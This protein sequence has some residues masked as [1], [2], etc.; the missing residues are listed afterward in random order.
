MSRQK[1]FAAGVV[2]VYEERIRRLRN[3]LKN[4][5]NFIVKSGGKSLFF[6][7]HSGLEA[8]E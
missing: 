6:L 7:R 1:R 2:C 8:S 3:H 5:R 4:V